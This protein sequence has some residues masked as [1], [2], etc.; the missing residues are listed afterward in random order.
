MADLQVVVALCRRAQ[1]A[2]S[3]QHGAQRGAELLGCVA[4][5][6]RLVALSSAR[7]AGGGGGGAP[8]WGAVEALLEV[9]AVLE[10]TCP[11]EVEAAWGAM[12]EGGG[13]H[14]SE[15]LRRLI[16]AAHLAL[17][18]PGQSTPTL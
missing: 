12:G 2:F 7:A 5:W 10:G 11:T 18:P 13:V 14:V 17:A 1:S 3:A 8:G 15:V 9:S 16:S 4:P 6:A